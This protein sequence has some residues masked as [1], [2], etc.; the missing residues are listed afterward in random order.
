MDGAGV[1]YDDKDPG[2]VALLMDTILSDHG[3]QDAIVSA[4][5]SAVDRLVSKDFAGTL[6][7]LVNRILA[8]PRAPKPRVA[9]DFWHQFD[10]AQELEELRLYRPAVFKALPEAP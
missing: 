8:A 5:L 10:A 7:G 9:F 4:Q 2:R 3:L 6:L 1:L